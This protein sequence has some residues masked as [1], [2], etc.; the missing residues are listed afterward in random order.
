MIVQ[1]AKSV[2]KNK[3]SSRK[4]KDKSSASNELLFR[5]KVASVVSIGNLQEFTKELHDLVQDFHKKVEELGAKFNVSVVDHV[6]F[7]INDK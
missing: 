6:S 3:K 5:N 1:T 2:V 7:E 4:P